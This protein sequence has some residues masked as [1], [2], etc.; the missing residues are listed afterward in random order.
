MIF[1]SIAA[2]SEESGELKHDQVEHGTTLKAMIGSNLL[3][4]NLF[5]TKNELQQNFFIEL[6]FYAIVIIRVTL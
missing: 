1:K 4:I 3:I 5:I 6:N 2:K